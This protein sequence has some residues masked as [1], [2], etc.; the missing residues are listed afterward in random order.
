MENDA[1]L[2]AMLSTKQF[3]Q[4]M[5]WASWEINESTERQAQIEVAINNE[6]EI[7]ANSRKKQAEYQASI[8][9]N[10]A[11]TERKNANAEKLRNNTQINRQIN[12]LMLVVSWEKWILSNQE[13]SQALESIANDT[14]LQLTQQEKNV[15]LQLAESYK[16]GGST[17]NVGKKE[18]N[19]IR[20]VAQQILVL[21]MSSYA[22]A[23]EEKKIKKDL[24]T[25]LQLL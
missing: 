9:S 14:K 17:S 18:K 22:T 24:K 19:A 8:D 11:E 7:Q 20:S 4:Y 21:D 6:N 13:M 25:F 23:Q 10:R 15:Y 2:F 12:A 16:N 3:N 1:N 5:K